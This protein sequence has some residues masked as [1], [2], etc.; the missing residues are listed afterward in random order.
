MHVIR[1]RIINI[2]EEGKTIT[3]KYILKF[4]ESLLK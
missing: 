3:T 1:E 2:R 4:L